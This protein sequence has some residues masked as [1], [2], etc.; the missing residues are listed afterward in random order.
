MTK[1]I[2]LLQRNPTST[3]PNPAD[4]YFKKNQ[5]IVVNPVSIILSLVSRIAFGYVRQ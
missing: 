4:F 2:F 5:K 1:H 3:Q